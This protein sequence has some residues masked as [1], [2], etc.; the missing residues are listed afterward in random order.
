MSKTDIEDGGRRL[1]DMRLRDLF[2][3]DP[4]RVAAFTFTAPHLTLDL[5][6]QRIDGDAL[7]ALARLA[8]SQDVAGW[9][10]RMAGGEIVNTTEGRAARHMALRAPAPP[11]E[12]SETRARMRALA[13]AIA[14]GALRGAGGAVISNIL[15][16]GIGGSDLGPRLVADALKD[17]RNGALTLRFAANIDGAD[18][19]EAVEGLD[20]DRTLVIVVSKTFTTLE[21]LFNAGLARDWLAGRGAVAAVTA[22][23]RRAAAW[24][25]AEEHIFPFWDWVGGRYSLWSAVGLS[26]AIALSRDGAAEP[27][28]T[29]F[30]RL[31][32][33]AAEMDAHFLKAPFERNAPLITAA[34]QHWNR[35][36]LNHKSYAIAPYAHRLQLLPAYLQQLEM[37]SNGKG[38]GR[39]GEALRRAASVV[40]WGAVGANA[41]H[42]FFQMLHQGVEETPV[43]FVLVKDAGGPGRTALMANALAQAQALM[44]GRSTAE[45]HADMVGQGL[46]GADADRLAPHRAFPGDRATTILALDDLSP[47][48]VGA[49]IAFYEHRTVAQA[50]LAGINPFDQYG[51]ELG[52][53]M[54]RALTPALDG[55]APPPDDP[56]TA[57]WIARLRG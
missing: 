3:A 55:D 50:F 23:P 5:S 18:F 24:G 36:A 51:V 35:A 15:H 53:E 4:N 27:S 42:S 41:Q 25:V 14:R 19:A 34:A 1:A 45:A 10:D 47:E 7:A 33:G 28:G 16:I 22:A 6:R 48:S 29:V 13:A 44:H 2:A 11:A 8:V 21:T 17:H 52:K 20:P 49:L 12:V 43:E 39:D 57:A 56:A 38:V 32:A 46:S 30:D 31:L 9:R 40:T 54:A 37:E 26:C